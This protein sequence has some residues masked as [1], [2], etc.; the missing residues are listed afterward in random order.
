MRSV[1]S[2]ARVKTDAFA[3]RPQSGRP[4]QSQRQFGMV[5]EKLFHQAR[6][7]AGKSSLKT[8]EMALDGRPSQKTWVLHLVA[9][10]QASHSEEAEAETGFEAWA[11]LS[12]KC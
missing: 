1:L 5:C 4:L 7:R 10:L 11:P 6:R 9:N 3:R 2:C 12:Q 8:L